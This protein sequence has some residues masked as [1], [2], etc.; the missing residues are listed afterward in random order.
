MKKRF[1]NKL[2]KL[3]YSTKTN[4]IIENMNN[5]PFNIVDKFHKIKNLFK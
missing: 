1:K 3:V 2:L 5:N 4:G